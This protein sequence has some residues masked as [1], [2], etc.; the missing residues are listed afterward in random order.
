MTNFFKLVGIFAAIF[1]DGWSG[2]LSWNWG[3][4][5]VNIGENKKPL[6]WGGKQVVRLYD[7]SSIKTPTLTSFFSTLKEDPIQILPFNFFIS[8]LTF[9]WVS[10]HNGLIVQNRMNAAIPALPAGRTAHYVELLWG[11]T[12]RIKCVFIYFLHVGN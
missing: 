7:C 5:F 8:S 12:V 2:W 6:M 10:L 1:G 11:L 4:W 9:F 3:F